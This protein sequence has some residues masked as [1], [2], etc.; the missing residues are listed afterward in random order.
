MPT[1]PARPKIYHITHVDNLQAIAAVSRRLL[2]DMR[3][4][5]LGGPNQ[6]VGMSH[7]KERRMLE[8]NMEECYPEDFVGEYV[9]F[10]FCPRSVMLYLIYMRNHEL[11]YKGGQGPIVHLQADLQTVVDWAEENERRWAFSLSNAGAYGVEF[12]ND[13]N[14][15]DEINWPAVAAKDWRSSSI[16]H[17][18]QAEFLLRDFFPWHLVERIG[19]QS[20]AIAQRAAQA[21]A[22]VAHQPGIEI[23]QEWYYP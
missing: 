10:Y 6:M 7:I 14:Q 22:A 11:T 9:P 12:R 13:L 19:V 16:K 15:L 23:L 20:N 4:A 21:I 5:G 17:G 3:L 2:S 1:P 18:K 8:I